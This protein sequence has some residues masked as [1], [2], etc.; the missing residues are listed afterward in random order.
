MQ[1]KKRALVENFSDLKLHQTQFCCPRC[2][3]SK[4]AS[5][6]H[7][8]QKTQIDCKKGQRTEVG[9]TFRAVPACLFHWWSQ[10]TW[11]LPAARIEVKAP[12]GAGPGSQETRSHDFPVLAVQLPVR[13]P[14][15][16]ST[17]KVSRLFPL[18]VFQINLLDCFRICVQV[19][20]K[21]R[22]CNISRASPDLSHLTNVFSRRFLSTVKNKNGVPSCCL[23]SPLLGGAL[24]STCLQRWPR[25]RAQ[26]H[27][28]NTLVFVASL[29]PSQPE[30]WTIF[31]LKVA[32]NKSSLL[33]MQLSILDA[34]NNKCFP[35]VSFMLN[36]F[37]H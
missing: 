8:Q 6:L 16:P 32:R 30:K 17:P 33:V 18:S 24:S 7:L 34:M 27:A 21:E 4:R 9:E 36:F 28:G 20:V 14:Q 12:G 2:D 35:L 3:A 10:R 29:P 1:A 25:I 26:Q 5:S 22:L 15:R 31:A 11:Y 13:V 37:L 19:S 23:E